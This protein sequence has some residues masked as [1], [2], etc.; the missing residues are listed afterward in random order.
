MPMKAISR[1]FYR[2]STGWFVLATLIVL[3][4][5]SIATLP[6]ENNRVQSYSK[7]LGSPD[8]SLFYNGDTIYKMAEIYES[9]GREAYIQAR[10]SFDLAFPLIYT[11]F[12]ISTISYLFIVIHLDGGKSSLLN[13]LPLLGLVFDLAENVSASL[14]MAAYP[15]VSI[16]QS[17]AP[18]FTPLKWLFVSASFLLIFVTLFVWL[19]RLIFTKRD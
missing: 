9:A 13:L 7:G 14:V 2:N 17:L 10:W 6:V 3:L 1:F 15:R 12:F 16:C 11:L 5:F 4:G 18:I 8:T 19:G